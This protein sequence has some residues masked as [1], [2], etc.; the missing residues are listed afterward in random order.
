MSSIIFSITMLSQHHS[1]EG[2]W[3]GLEL[4]LWWPLWKKMSYHRIWGCPTLTNL[5]V[6]SLS[7]SN[8]TWVPS[9]LV[10]PLQHL[11]LSHSASMVLFHLKLALEILLFKC[12]PNKAVLNSKSPKI[13]AGC[14]QKLPELHPF[15]IWFLHTD[16]SLRRAC[17]EFICSGGAGF[18]FQLPEANLLV[19]SKPFSTLI[20]SKIIYLDEIIE[21]IIC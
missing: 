18:I 17:T 3:W 7:C 11:D 6:L 1:L 12:I 16:D 8:L 9:C 10:V 4:V 20:I 15:C 5:T 13:P 21:V 2:N 14:F 19:V